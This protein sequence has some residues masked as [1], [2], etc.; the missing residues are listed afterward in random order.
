MNTLAIKWKVPNKK[1]KRND[2]PLLDLLLEIT[3]DHSKTFS[4]VEYLITKS[5]SVSHYE[6][7]EPDVSW[8]TVIE[9]VNRNDFDEIKD[10]YIDLRE[11][12]KSSG[13]TI[14]LSEEL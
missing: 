8:M 6:S 5:A 9:T 11:K 1:W 12:Y 3:D 4:D 2:G 10:F 14:V 7:A 13:I